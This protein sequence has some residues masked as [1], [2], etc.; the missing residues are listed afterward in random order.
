MAAS[1]LLQIAALVTA[2][3]LWI[4]HAL[5]TLSGNWTADHLVDFVCSSR[6]LK[7]GLPMACYCYYWFDRNPNQTASRRILI[8]GVLATVLAVAL[9]RG[10]AHLLPVR[11]RPFADPSSGFIPFLPTNPVDYEDWSSFPSDTA[12][13]EFALCWSLLGVSRACSVTL[14][15]YTFVTACLT[16]I[17]IG[18]HYP[19]D[20]V[21]GA[22]IGILCASLMQRV[23]IKS[24]RLRPIIGGDGNH[25]LFYAI[26]FLVAAELAQIFDNLRSAKRSAQALLRNPHQSQAVTSLAAPRQ[27]LL[28]AVLIAA[29]I[30]LWRFFRRA[31]QRKEKAAL[32]EPVKPVTTA[33]L[34]GAGRDGDNRVHVGED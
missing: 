23:P 19:S 1:W 7:G 26:A 22:L 13:F 14:T 3:D 9:T 10:F 30:V 24:A 15:L 27:L 2:V 11:L 16:R 5:N 28:A 25:P 12:A 18:V 33:R 4:I 6:I 34:G 32:P 21:A 20:I 8:R 17:Y 29:S 31:G